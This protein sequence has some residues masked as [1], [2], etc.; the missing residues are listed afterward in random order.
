MDNET[1]IT[2]EEIEEIRHILY[3]T[4]LATLKNEYDD[5]IRSKKRA[6]ET[7]DRIDILREEGIPNPAFHANSLRQLG[8]PVFSLLCL[9]RQEQVLT[10]MKTVQDNMATVQTAIAKDSSRLT[11]LTI[12]LIVLTAVLAIREFYDFL[13]WLF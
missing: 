4:A 9:E 7:E 12:A 13:C 1:E 8:V 2:K 5:Y 10:V 6:N 3:Q 11:K